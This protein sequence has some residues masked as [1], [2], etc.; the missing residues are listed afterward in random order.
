MRLNAMFALS[1]AL[2]CFAPVM[3]SGRLM[4]A[5]LVLEVLGGLLLLLA[6]WTP[7]APRQ[8][9]WPL[10]V[11]LAGMVLLPLVYLVPLP[12]HVWQQLPGRELYA[13]SLAV[14]EQAGRSPYLALTLIPQR[15]VSSL[16]ALMPMSGIVLAVLLLPLGRVTQ[17]VYAFLFVAGAEALLGLFQYVSGAEWLFGWVDAKR[18]LAVGT[19]ANPDHFAA[20]M[21]MALPVTLALTAYH[22]YPGRRSR[23]RVAGSPRHLNRAGVFFGLALFLLLAGVFTRSRAGVLLLMLAILLVAV[24]FARHIGGRRSVGIGTVIMVV[25]LA[26]AADIGLMPVLSRFS[27]DPMEDVRW[28]TYAATWQAIREFFPVGSGSGSFQ[29]VFLAFHPPA[30]PQFINHVHNDYL[31]LLFETGAAGAALLLFSGVVYAYGWWRLR[32]RAWGMF[33]FIQ[34][35]AGLAMV[36]LM[37][38]GLLDFVFHTPANAVF[39]AFLTGVFLH[40]G[41]G[42]TAIHPDI[43]ILDDGIPE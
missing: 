11:L 35:A 9:P 16:L 14:L 23:E 40:Q 38:H 27:A 4:T 7:A 25:A 29:A 21:V 18:Y 33:R 2:L 41:E 19:Y 42:K 31:E 15:T 24:V 39:F 1:L 20:L 30:L 36:L 37:L 6:L 43:T 8:I 13:Q 28:Q 34:V 22:V 32:G 17:L 3:R 5:M 10:K 26:V 12:V